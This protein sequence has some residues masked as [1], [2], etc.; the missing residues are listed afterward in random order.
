MPVYAFSNMTVK[1]SVDGGEFVSPSAV[2]VS[3]TIPEDNNRVV[4]EI[5]NIPDVLN[6]KPTGNYTELE[7]IK[8][9]VARLD[10]TKTYIF[11][12]EG[13]VNARLWGCEMWNAKRLDV[14]V[15][16]Y[17]GSSAYQQNTTMRNG[18]YSSYHKPALVISDYL[19]LNDTDR[20]N[21]RL[22]TIE[23]WKEGNTE[24]GLI[25]KDKGIPHLV[26]ITH[27]LS[28]RSLSY[29]TTYINKLAVQNSCNIIDVSKKVIINPPTQSLTG[30]DGLH[31]SDYGNQYYFE[32]L[33]K[34]FD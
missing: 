7:N 18:W 22:D 19:Y 16:A 25:V 21:K 5:L 4:N 28:S 24:L 34:I 10:P 13:N 27:H 12:I 1:V 6:T 32:E 8:Y 11:K 3:Y 20:I 31:L 29:I 17:S 2:T 14:V 33:K 23:Q 26:F 15:E 30:A 9:S